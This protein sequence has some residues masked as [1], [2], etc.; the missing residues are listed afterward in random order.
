[1]SEAQSFLKF[2]LLHLFL[3]R[4]PFRV[5]GL[6]FRCNLRCHVLDHYWCLTRFHLN[7]GTDHQHSRGKAYGKYLIPFPSLAIRFL[8]IS[9]QWTPISKWCLELQEANVQ[10][11]LCLHKVIPFLRTFFPEPERLAISSGTCCHLH[12]F[13]NPQSYT[14]VDQ[15]QA[16]SQ[17]TRHQ[18]I[19]ASVNLLLQT[20]NQIIFSFSKAH[21]PTSSHA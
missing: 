20:T 12:S 16:K 4:S 10:N 19:I 17:K 9:Q 18:T 11:Q 3:A 14:K 2:F 15:V 6:E 1:M 8:Q 21:V 7:P 13:L 5:Y